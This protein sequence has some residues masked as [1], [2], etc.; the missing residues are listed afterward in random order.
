MKLKSTMTK[1]NRTQR[2]NDTTVMTA[3]HS[4]SFIPGNFANYEMAEDIFIT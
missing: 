1:L 3:T 4:C 2:G